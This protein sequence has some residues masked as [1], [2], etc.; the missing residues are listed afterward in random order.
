M[1]CIFC[2]NNIKATADQVCSLGASQV[3]A[4][5]IQKRA[6]GMSGQFLK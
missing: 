2:R 6:I 3:K 5:M 1:V 4:E